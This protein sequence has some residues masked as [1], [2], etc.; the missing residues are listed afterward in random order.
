MLAFA[1]PCRLVVA[2]ASRHRVVV[3][4]AGRPWLRFTWRQ[5]RNVFGRSPRTESCG[6]LAA[7]QR[8]N[9]IGYGVVIATQF[10]DHPKALRIWHPINERC[11]FHVGVDRAK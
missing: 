10:A 3:R 1:M 11:V 9:P 8:S 4:L 7:L 5:C 6:E 2:E